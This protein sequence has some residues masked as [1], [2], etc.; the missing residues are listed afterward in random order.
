MPHGIRDEKGLNQSH[1]T[2]PQ[3]DHSSTELPQFGHLQICLAPDGKEFLYEVLRPKPNT[4]RN[5]MCC[6]R[7]DLSPFLGRPAMASRSDSRQGPHKEPNLV[8]LCTTASFLSLP[9]HTLQMSQK[10][11][12]GPFVQTLRA[13]LSW[14]MA[15]KV[16]KGALF[17]EWSPQA[18]FLT[19]C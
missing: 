4:Y 19:A 13:P 9:S 11:G 1:V 15:E 7:P 16:L 12:P 17:F 10:S 2:D 18:E 14:C 3:E 6:P 5:G 8:W